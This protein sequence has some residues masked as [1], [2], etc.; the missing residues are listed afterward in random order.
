MSASQACFDEHC[1]DELTACFGAFFGVPPECEEICARVEDLCGREGRGTNRYYYARGQRVPL[2][3]EPSMVVVELAPGAST[4]K[5]RVPGVIWT[6][7]DKTRGGRRVAVAWLRPL[8]V[9]AA[10]ASVRLLATPGIA[11]L[12]PVYRSRAGRLLGDQGRIVVRLGAAPGA[13]GLKDLSAAHGFTVVGPVAGLPG[14]W[15]LSTTSADA[16]ASSVHLVESRAVAWA[17]PDFLLDLRPRRVPNDTW[18]GRQW[19][20]HNTGQHG[21][22]GGVD[23]VDVSHPDLRFADDGSGSPLVV[24]APGN[25][26]EVL[27]MG[28]AVHGTAVAGVAAATGD[29]ERGVA[30][31]CPSCTVLPVYMDLGMG[32]EESATAL[33]FT[34]SAEA[35]AWVINNSWGP[36]DGVPGVVDP[37]E[38]PEEP[39]SDVIHEAIAKVANEARSGKGMVVV[40]AAGNGNEDV[41]SDPFAAHPDVIGVAALD[42]SGRKASY[43]DFGDGVWVTAPSN[44]FGDAFIWSTDA[45]GLEHGINIEGEMRH[46]LEEACDGRDNDG[47]GSVDEEGVCTAPE[48]DEPCRFHGQ[49]GAGRS[50]LDGQCMDECV[51]AEGCGDDRPCLELT[52]RYGA[53]A[54]RHV[55]LDLGMGCGVQCAY[56][57]MFLPDGGLESFAEC[58]AGAMSCEDGYACWP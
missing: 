26:A 44:G 8:S 38:L 11:K 41:G 15:V 4:Q 29:N 19:Y 1:M 36:M 25:N 3:L 12:Y 43:S 21:L 57:S 34:R 23:G 35:G 53:G 33:S 48:P 54:G 52:D 50:C 2:F 32:D 51:P 40:F 18:F 22:R 10:A 28:M 6:G 42:A 58:V 20:L 7:R 14:V 39:M 9:G 45:R 24:D 5:I 56:R 37:G 49:C 46:P 13:P 31:V 17:H 27:A 47:D 16:V 55:C 30:G